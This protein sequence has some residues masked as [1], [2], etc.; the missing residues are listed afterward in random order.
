VT[1]VAA[2]AMLAAQLLVSAP[3]AHASERDDFW[4]LQPLVAVS[5]DEVRI[6]YVSDGVDRLDR[7]LRH[8]IGI[9]NLPA[10]RNFDFC[11][12]A[13]P[14]TVTRNGGIIQ[15]MGCNFDGYNDWRFEPTDVAGLY[16]IRIGGERCMDADNRFGIR[17]G[18]RVQLWDCLGGWDLNQY[19]W[20]VGDDEH[21]PFQLVNDADGKC[22]SSLNSGVELRD[23]DP[24][25]IWDCFTG[26]RA[27][28]QEMFPR[29]WS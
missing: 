16:R 21:G 20:L 13:E 12:E 11:V 5:W 24:S 19:W 23:Y 18:D 9:L 26:G 3:A 6:G 25:I 29:S 28:T 15:V 2:A 22:L 7:T 14:I 27:W 1:A 17:N 10:T 8:E 4:S